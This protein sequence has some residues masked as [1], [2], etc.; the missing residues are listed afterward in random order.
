MSSTTA[1]LQDAVDTVVARADNDVA[2]G[3]WLVWLKNYT[4]AI[5]DGDKTA[6]ITESYSAYIKWTLYNSKALQLAQDFKPIDSRVHRGWMTR[7]FRQGKRLVRDK[8]RAN[9]LLPLLKLALDEVEDDARDDTAEALQVL[10]TRTDQVAN[11]AEVL[12]EELSRERSYTAKLKETI[13]DY[14]SREQDWQKTTAEQ[15][16]QIRRLKEAL[17]ACEQRH[18]DQRARLPDPPAPD[19]G[20]EAVTELVE[21]ALAAPLPPPPPGPPP[22]PP[23]APKPLIRDTGAFNRMVKETAEDARDQADKLQEINGTEDLFAEIRAKKTVLRSVPK[24]FTKESALL[25]AER[26]G[27]DS[28]AALLK[29]RIA[30]AG[31][32]AVSGTEG[33][34]GDENDESGWETWGED[35]DPAVYGYARYARYAQRPAGYAR[36][37]ERQLEHLLDAVGGSVMAAARMGERL[38]VKRGV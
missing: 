10:E 29:R 25:K 4:Q 31:P 1:A 17:E 27:D 23:A 35:D 15:E 38:C 22:P 12:A 19:S 3:K 13:E 7:F 26:E 8:R 21:E 18:E 24:S 5:A 16:E 28:I 37:T 9:A 32:G 11:S 34:E 6:K 33:E 2:A 14:K 30:I 20:D 36:F